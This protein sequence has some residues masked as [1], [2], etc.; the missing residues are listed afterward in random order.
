MGRKGVWLVQ[1][2]FV[3]TIFHV[4]VDIFVKIL[5]V[6][7]QSVPDV[8]ILAKNALKQRYVFLANQMIFIILQEMRTTLCAKLLLPVLPG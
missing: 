4:K 7:E 1:V 3:V 2:N 8:I 5:N 6:K